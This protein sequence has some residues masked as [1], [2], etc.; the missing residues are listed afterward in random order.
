MEVRPLDWSPDNWAT[1]WPVVRNL[2]AKYGKFDLDPCAERHTAKA[3]RFYTRGDD[4]LG[5]TGAPIGS[6]RTGSL[7]AVLPAQL[8]AGWAAE[9]CA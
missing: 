2:E 5:R 6:P 4:G 9:K 7:I 8:A 1:P 3:P